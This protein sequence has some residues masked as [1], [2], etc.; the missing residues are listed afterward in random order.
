MAPATAPAPIGTGGLSTTADP[1]SRNSS[2]ST[3]TMIATRGASLSTAVTSWIR[4]A[5][6]TPRILTAT[7]AQISASAITKA[8]APPA[9]TGNGTLSALTTA[10]ASAPFPAQ[11]R[12]Q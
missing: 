12:I 8:G 2:Q 1:P 6:A 10:I 9:S 7:S 5:S 4:P 11:M 3:T